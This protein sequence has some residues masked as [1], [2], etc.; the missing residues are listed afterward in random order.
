L[1]FRR[2]WQFKEVVFDYSSN[3]SSTFQLYTDLPGGAMAARKGAGVTMASTSD[4]RKTL[5]IP[6]DGIEGTLYRPEIIPGATTVL[7]LYGGTIWVRPVG[8]Y[9][10][11]SLSEKWTTQEMALGV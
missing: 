8:V 6:L 11:G 3:N 2:V 9:L 4:G 10:D 1:A 5:P 7:R